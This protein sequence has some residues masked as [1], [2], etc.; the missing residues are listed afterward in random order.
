MIRALLGASGRHLARDRASLLLSF[1]L[2]VA[3]F[4]VT[5]LAFGGAAG[6]GTPRVPLLVTDLDGSPA[7]RSLRETLARDETIK[8]E[9]DG[10]PCADRRCA[11][12][13]AIASVES[14]GPAA[15]SFSRRDSAPPA[16]R[17]ARPGSS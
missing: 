12:A 8:L 5:A 11:T 17:A 2:P 15:P 10:F 6:S 7:S 4:S 14:S 3:F 1:L 9:I 13:R 16:R